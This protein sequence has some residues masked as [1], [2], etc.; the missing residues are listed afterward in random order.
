V[1]VAFAWSPDGY[2]RHAKFVLPTA[3][4]P[5][6]LDD[7]EGRVTTP[8]VKAPEGVVDPVEFIAKASLADALKEVKPKEDSGWR[9]P[10]T[11]ALDATASA[12]STKVYQESNL[13]LAPRHV[14]VAPGAG[15]AENDEALLQTSRGR[16]PVRVVV[17]AG[18]PAGK[19][20]YMGTP[21]VL[22]L[23]GSE[24]PKVVRA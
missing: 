13:L 8:L 24:E 11:G 20:R 21:D 23:C 1:T 9:R 18:L 19:V 5:E 7:V 17:D 10:Y 16:L 6:A 3:V 4:F 2:A 14:A 15:L 12:L 22:D